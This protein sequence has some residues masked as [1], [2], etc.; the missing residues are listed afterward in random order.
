MFLIMATRVA[1]VWLSPSL[2][3]VHKHASC[4]DQLEIQDSIELQEI[5]NEAGSDKISRMYQLWS[6]SQRRQ[7][8]TALRAKH[9]GE[10]TVEEIYEQELIQ[11]V[12]L[13]KR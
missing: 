11:M 4:W 12:S 1:P 9:V 2:S 3:E 8:L 13:G 5:R 10:N 6:R 7:L